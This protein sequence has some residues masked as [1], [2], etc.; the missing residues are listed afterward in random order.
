[1]MRQTLRSALC[2]TLLLATWTATH[3]GE[4]F[5]FKAG[6]RVMFLGDSITEQYQYST[7][8][9]L[10]LATRFPAWKLSFMNA[11]ISGDT[12]TGGANRFQQ[13][14]LD[15]QPTVV[16]IN[17]G[18]NDGGYGAFD[19]NRNKGFVDNTTKMLQMSKDAGVRVVLMSPNAVDVR[20]GER[21][22]L[23]LET[24]K[25]FYEPLK[26]LAAANQAT[27]VDQYAITRTGLE[28]MAADKADAANPFPD[29]FHTGPSGG[30]FMAHAILTG[31]HAPAVVSEVSIPA[32]G[33]AQVT[34]AAVTNLKREG[35]TLSFE[36][37]DEA[38][39]MPIPAD[40]DSVLPY[41][42]QLKDLNWYG[43]KA[44]GLPA[45]KY[46]ISIDDTKVATF[47]A[48]E[49]AAGVNLGNLRVGPVYEQ[50]AKVFA[51]IN[52]KNGTVHQRFRGVILAAVP[53]WLA[54]VA[55][56]RKPKEL[57]RRKQLIDEQQT[58]IHELALPVKHV[59]TINPAS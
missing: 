57:A 51:A 8:V 42:N 15:E 12:A 36:R 17:F 1:M 4:D 52:A 13:Q 50:A 44:A 20:K 33:E 30:L 41:V 48:E 38:L 16:T 32:T 14:V 47:T 24:Q 46:D 55:V 27:F 6:D 34:R 26:A 39:P 28:K 19:P 5:P 25:Q 31:L 11:G 7:D 3:A 49:L 58:A 29:G 22:K 45:G 35:A 40:W 37:L 21:F 9:E 59:W 56:E 10:Y 53:D 54:D 18:M 2:F 23:Y 43:V